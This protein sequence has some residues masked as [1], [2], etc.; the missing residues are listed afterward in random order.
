MLAICERRTLACR[1]MPGSCL[2]RLLTSLLPDLHSRLVFCSVSITPPHRSSCLLRTNSAHPWDASPGWVGGA[3]CAAC[4]RADRASL[5]FLG[6]RAR[7]AQ[8]P[9]SAPPTSRPGAEL[10]SSL[11][12]GELFQVFPLKEARPLSPAS[13]GGAGG[14]V[15]E[16]DACQV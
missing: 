2:P 12:R 6:A 1:S 4:S 5:Q 3:A 16:L 7:G 11:R 10:R 15:G 13:R 8:R 14:W 9:G